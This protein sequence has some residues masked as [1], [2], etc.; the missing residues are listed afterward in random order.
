MFTNKLISRSFR[1]IRRNLKDFKGDKI[2]KK[3]IINLG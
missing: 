3:T 2:Y 1:E